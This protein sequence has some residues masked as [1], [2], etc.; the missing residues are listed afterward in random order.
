MKQ[1]LDPT[2]HSHKIERSGDERGWPLCP[3]CGEDEV[4]SLIWNSDR[5]QPSLGEFLAGPLA[6]YSCGQRWK[7]IN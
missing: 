5:P 7:A 1:R 6:C 2:R 4:Y 3:V